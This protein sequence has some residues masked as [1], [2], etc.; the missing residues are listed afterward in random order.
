MSKVLF[1]NIPFNGHVNPTL[2]R[3]LKKK[4]EYLIE[5]TLPLRD[6]VKIV[7]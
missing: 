3:N 7:D 4:K 1:L 5:S 6:N 2:A